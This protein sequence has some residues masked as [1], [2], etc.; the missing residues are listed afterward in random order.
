[1]EAP[2]KTSSN[3][4][5]TQSW[6]AR[7]SCW[8]RPERPRTGGGG[9]VR[10]VGGGGGGGV[11]RGSPAYLAQYVVIR[12]DLPAGFRDGQLIHAARKSSQ[13]REWPEG[14]YAIA[15][16]VADEAELRAL[17]QRLAE[18]GLSRHLIIEDDPP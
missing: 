1:M 7:P 6:R 5:R 18:A 13:G 17:D 16:C 15:L 14:T 11:R 10:R 3:L 12:S 9:G 8:R 2:S 4:S